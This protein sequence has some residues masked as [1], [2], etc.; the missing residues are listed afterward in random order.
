MGQKDVVQGGDTGMRGHVAILVALAAV[1]LYVGFGGYSAAELAADIDRLNRASAEDVGAEIESDDVVFADTENFRLMR[2]S[3]RV[4]AIWPWTFWLSGFVVMMLTS[5]SFGCLGGIARVLKCV[6]LDRKAMTEVNV[7]GVLLLG[8]ILALI[9]YALSYL[10]PL[11]VVSKEGD[12]LSPIAVVVVSL[13]AGLF[14]E[15]AYAWIERNAKRIFGSNA[16]DG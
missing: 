16:K 9:V 1:S 5:A 12:V 3:E 14:A 13:L 7:S 10:V 6:V 2:W 15:L 11:A 4:K 8:A